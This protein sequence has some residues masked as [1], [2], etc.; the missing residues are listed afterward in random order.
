LVLDAPE[1]TEK[2][3]RSFRW[4]STPKPL[5]VNLISMLEASSRTGGDIPRMKQVF[6]PQESNDNPFDVTLV[7]AD[8]REF[9]AH[10]RVLLEASPFSV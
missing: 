9:K 2:E 10:R 3:R 8:G 1:K 6:I 5:R 4:H 7:I